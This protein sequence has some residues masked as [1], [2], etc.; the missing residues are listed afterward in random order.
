MEI[1]GKIVIIT[2]ASS[3]IGEAT[4]RLLAQQGAKVVLVARSKEKLEKLSAELPGSMVVVADLREEKQVRKMIADVMK[5][6]GKVDV[7]INNAGRGYLSSLEDIETEK[8]RELFELNL[9]APLAAMQEVIPVMRK[10]GGGSI[11]NISSGTALGYFPNLSAYASLKRA[12]GGLTLTGRDEL[13]KDKII[14][15]LVY[16]YMTKTEFGK[17]LMRSGDSERAWRGRQ[18]LPAGDSAEVVA[19]KV[20]EAMTSGQAEVFVRDFHRS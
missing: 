4:A 16:P 5:Q 14:L 11:V 13:A 19:E 9:V 18:D 17:N 20:L 10:Q 2:G 7:L 15:S 6:Y 3:G 8:L 12:L 1:A